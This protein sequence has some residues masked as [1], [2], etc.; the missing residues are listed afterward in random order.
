MKLHGIEGFGEHADGQ[1][2]RAVD[3]AERVMGEEVFHVAN[4]ELCS[5]K[6]GALGANSGEV[7]QGGMEDGIQ[8]MIKSKKGRGKNRSFLK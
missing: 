4:A 5:E 2:F 3:V 6:I 1:D 8:G 7:W